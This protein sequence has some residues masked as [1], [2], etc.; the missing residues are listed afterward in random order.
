MTCRGRGFDSL[1]RDFDTR[2]LRSRASVFWLRSIMAGL[3]H[4]SRSFERQD[5]TQ[6][7]TDSVALSS[8]SEAAWASS[9]ESE[10]HAT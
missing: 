9:L 8:R 2:S 4:K 5:S 6:Q 1:V 10:A 3:L 7:N